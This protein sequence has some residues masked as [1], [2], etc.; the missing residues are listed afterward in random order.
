MVQYLRGEIAPPTVLHVRRLAP[1]EG[2]E[3]NSGTRLGALTTHWQLMSDPRIAGD[4]RSLAEAAATVGGR[5]TQNVGT[6]AGNV[7]NASPAADLLPPLLVAN[8]VVTLQSSV[9]TREIGLSDFLLGRKR[10]AREPNELVTRISLDRPGSRTGE[11]YLK[12]GRRH[13]M[14][15]AVVGLAARLSFAED[16]TVTEARIAVCSVAPTPFRAPEV[17]AALTGTALEEAAVAEAGELLRTSASPIDDAR[18]TAAYRRRV[19][20]SLLRQ[21]VHACRS[22]AGL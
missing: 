11:I 21:A 2:I 6:V 15:V 19:L 7:V 16:A 5:Q 14:E 13:A 20:A 17:E 9:R 22:R 4:H 1:L 8:A 12:V 18:A 10:T 3:V